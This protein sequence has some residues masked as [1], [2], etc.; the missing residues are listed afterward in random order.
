[1]PGSTGWTPLPGSNSGSTPAD[2]V[3]NPPGASTVPYWEVDDLDRALARLEA[4]GA[5]RHRGPL[6]IDP[7]RRIAQ[8]QDPFGAV[9]GLQGH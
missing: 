1:M 7:A 6:T 8:V 5:A 9:I 4:A 2:P 3:K